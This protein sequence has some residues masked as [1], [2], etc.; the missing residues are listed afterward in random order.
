MRPCVPLLAMALIAL[1]GCG[2]GTEVSAPVASVVPMEATTTATDVEVVATA[3]VPDESTTTAPVPTTAPEVPYWTP[4]CAESE[5]NGLGSGEVVPEFVGLGRQPSLDIAIPGVVTSAGPYGSIASTRAIPGGVLVSV[6]PPNG[7][8]TPDEILTSSSLVAIDHDGTVRWR[9]CFVDLEVARV[10]VAP[11]PTRPTSAWVFSRA[12]DQPLEVVRVDLATGADVAFE[13]DVTDLEVRGVGGRFVVLGV[14]SDGPTIDA[15][16]EMLLLDVLDGSIETVPYPPEAHGHP[17]DAYFTIHDADS[18]DSDAV[19]VLGS[20]SPGD[21]RAVRSGGVWTTDPDVLRAVLPPAV[22]E[23]FGEPFELRLLDV[24]GG[25][26]WAAEE[27]HGI[28]REGFRWAIGDSVVVAV[29]CAEWDAD[30]ICPWLGD[31]PPREE[32]VAFDLASGDELWSTPGARA[33]PVVAGDL[34][35][36]T[37]DDGGYELVDLRTG[38]RVGGPWPAGSFDQECCGGDDYVH[39]E[40]D[41]GLVVATAW[42]RIRVWYPE[43][44]TSA[45][46]AVDAMG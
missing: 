5:G 35:I 44:A 21:A 20:L 43:S 25:L 18:A 38:A 28:S 3:T 27:F 29:R 14:G 34:G 42:D 10:V 36:G 17:G 24:A 19:I 32:V 30:G 40:R 33:F 6:L 11:A 1:A 9:R 15:G 4:G 39:V 16:S 26:I 23:T 7:W 22:S 46:V 31:E 37:I 12:W 45:T 13:I 41:G 2:G 8:P